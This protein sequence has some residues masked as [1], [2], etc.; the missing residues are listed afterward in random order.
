MKKN[1]NVIE[2][3]FI[4]NKEVILFG[5]FNYNFGHTGSNNSTWNNIINSF[6]LSHY[7]YHNQQE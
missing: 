2:K 4:E 6:N 3:T 1:E 7:L 5:D